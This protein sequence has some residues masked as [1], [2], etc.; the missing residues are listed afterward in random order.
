[1]ADLSVTASQVLKSTGA[2]T[3]TGVAGATITAGQPV[4]K[5]ATDSSELKLAGAAST[6]AVAACV[7]IAL[8]AALDGQPLTYQHA[9]TIIIGAAASVAEGVEYHLSTTAGA[10]TADAAVSTE[11]MTHL[12]VGNGS[13]GI[14]LKINASGQQVA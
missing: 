3:V 2:Q 14:V 11:Y 12:G 13:D 8:H 7:G 5:D 4:Y 10:I 1:M 6:A 9:G